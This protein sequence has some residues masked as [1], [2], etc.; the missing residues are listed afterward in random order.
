[1]FG[2]GLFFAGYILGWG[3]LGPHTEDIL[4]PIFLGW[5][6][7]LFSVPLGCGREIGPRLRVRRLRRRQRLLR[8]NH[9]RRPFLI[10]APN[11]RAYRRL[12]NS[13]AS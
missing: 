4:F 8:R 13:L 11:H 3:V 5:L 1:M 6:S 2:E 9:S 7:L 12:H 10:Q